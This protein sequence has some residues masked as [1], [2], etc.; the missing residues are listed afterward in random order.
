MLT[1]YGE[2]CHHRFTAGRA[3]G[4]TVCGVHYVT[5]EQH[6]EDEYDANCV[7]GVRPEASTLH[8][9]GGGAK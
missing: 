6:Q 5:T 1:T 4:R 7:L 8:D 2:R 9:G 3:H